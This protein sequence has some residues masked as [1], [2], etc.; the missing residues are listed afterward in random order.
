M[1]MVICEICLKLSVHHQFKPINP[2]FVRGIRKWSAEWSKKGHNWATWM[3]RV[4][5]MVKPRI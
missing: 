4:L 3:G 2:E 5:C 1:L